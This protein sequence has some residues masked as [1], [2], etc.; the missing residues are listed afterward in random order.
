MSCF[1]IH[2]VNKCDLLLK[3]NRYH[4][5][6]DLIEALKSC[7][8]S[9]RFEGWIQS[10]EKINRIDHHVHWEDYINDRPL[11]L[12]LVFLDESHVNMSIH[13]H[14]NDDVWIL[15]QI[16][17]K[18]G[19]AYFVTEKSFL[20]IEP[21]EHPKSRNDR[22]RYEIYWKAYTLEQVRDYPLLDY[23]PIQPYCSR[24]VASYNH[25]KERV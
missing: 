9:T 12:E 21:G 15:S 25:V 24:M 11:H 14:W 17:K 19:S 6:K 13:M 20:I 1:D 7:T 8:S 10:V 4:D 22:I 2:H 3:S 16:Q 5:V 23:T 18:D